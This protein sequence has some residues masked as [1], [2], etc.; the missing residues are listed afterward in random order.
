ME[1]DEI[2]EDTWEAIENEWLPYVKNEILSTA[3]WYARYIIGKEELT[4]FSMKNSITLL[5]LANK[6]FISLGDENDEDI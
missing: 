3:F 6:Y 4:N 2:F 1:Y 5:S